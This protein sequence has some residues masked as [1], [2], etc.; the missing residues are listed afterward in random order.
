MANTSIVVGSLA[1]VAQRNNQTLAESFLTADAIVLVDVS[2]SMSS[3]DAPGGHSRYDTACAELAKVQKSLPGKVAVV[4]FSS[5]VRFVPG[6][7]PPFDGGGTNLA[8]ALRF[9]QP[10]DGCVKFI[11]I[12]DGYPDS[13]ES[14]LKVAGKFTSEIDTVF[15]GPEGDDQGRAFLAQLARRAHGK[16]IESFKT[17]GLGDNVSLLLK[18]G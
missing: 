16:N 7:V 10:A 12:S 1:D 3:H 4:A 9:V 18:A 6:G 11:V 15:C 17:A 13:A 8:D 5:D 2:G 14:A